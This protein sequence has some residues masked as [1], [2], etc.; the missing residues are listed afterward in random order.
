MFTLDVLNVFKRNVTRTPLL[1]TPWLLSMMTTFGS[2]KKRYVQIKMLDL[3]PLANSTSTAHKEAL[4]ADAVLKY[5]R[6]NRI[7]VFIENGGMCP[8]S[9]RSMP[10]GVKCS[11]L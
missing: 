7:P 5:L 4:T 2:S 11:F 9:L 1:K 10:V 3:S 6:E 8:V